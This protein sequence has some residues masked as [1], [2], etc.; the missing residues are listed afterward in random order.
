MP[1]SL[2][3]TS[4]AHWSWWSAEPAVL[5]PVALLAWC[6][7]R[8][9][10]RLAAA[11]RREGRDGKD[12]VAS[13]GREAAFAGALLVVV[14][15]LQ[16]PLD[17][18][19]ALLFW[20]HMVQ[21]LLLLVVAAPLAVLGAPWLPLWAGAPAFV[22]RGATRLAGGRPASRLFSVLRP[23][24]TPPA[25]FAVFLVVLWAWHLPP[26][27]D[28]ALRVQAV[29]DVEHLTFL[30]A[31]VLFWSQVLASPPLPRR[32]G[33]LWRAGYMFAA[34]GQNVALAAAVGLSRVAWY[35][36]YASLA[37]RPGHVGALWDQQFG[38]GVM[39]T[40]GDV[41]FTIVLTASIAAWLTQPPPGSY[42]A[43]TP[44]AVT[45]VAGGGPGGGH[46]AIG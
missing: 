20:V 44:T 26:L 15:A 24:S 28:A 18:L 40:L 23:A 41:P 33:P 32:L 12:P 36:P 16:S 8:G 13:G 10:Q 38:A 29:H 11:S 30:G 1:S 5:V 46:R 34:M 42:P 45:A 9:W 17:R 6:Y 4:W 27:Y 37:D 31:G 2:L 14:L 7:G 39:W 21:H 35:A 19:S 25:S 3:W 43:G 22:R